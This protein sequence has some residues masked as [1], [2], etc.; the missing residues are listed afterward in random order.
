[1]LRFREPIVCV[2]CNKEHTYLWEFVSIL[3]R[4]KEIFVHCGGCGYNNFGRTLTED[5]I[6]NEG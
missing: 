4:K 5:E 2:N 6:I 1:M 3:F